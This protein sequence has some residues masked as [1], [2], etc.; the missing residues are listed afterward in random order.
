MSTISELNEKIRE[1]S[2][3]ING[4]PF[5]EQRT[6]LVSERTEL[7]RLRDLEIS[8]DNA[9]AVANEFGSGVMTN[10]SRTPEQRQAD[11]EAAD[12]RQRAR[13]QKQLDSFGDLLKPRR[14]NG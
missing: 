3:Q 11:T 2:Y 8:R 5:G 12:V 4:L 7:A 14:F 6:L 1:L 13:Q 10:D 9:A